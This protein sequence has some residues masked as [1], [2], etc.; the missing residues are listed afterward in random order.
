MNAN[1][2]ILT[3][4]ERAI[5][6]RTKLLG[7]SLPIADPLLA[8]VSEMLHRICAAQSLGVAQW[9]AGDAIGVLKKYVEKVIQ[10][11]NE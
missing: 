7:P 4:T 10:Q 3:A 9:I 5:S 8:E 11:G 1:P 6:E 2:K